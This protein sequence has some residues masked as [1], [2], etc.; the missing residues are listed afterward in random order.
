MI[1]WEWIDR[2]VTLWGGVGGF[3]ASEIK[4]RETR[5]LPLTSQTEPSRWERLSECIWNVFLGSLL[6]HIYIVS[7]STLSV[8]SATITGGSAP[9]ILKNL[10]SAL[11][12]QLPG[13]TEP[14]PPANK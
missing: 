4:R 9:L 5:T 12:H 11:P 2:S 8:L 13:R 7:G 10:L 6:V 3:V 14:P 1:S